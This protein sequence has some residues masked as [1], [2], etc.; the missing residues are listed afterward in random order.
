MVIAHRKINDIQPV[1]T[2]NMYAVSVTRRLTG[3]WL[4]S[5]E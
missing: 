1:S 3:E 4:I 2:S 5:S